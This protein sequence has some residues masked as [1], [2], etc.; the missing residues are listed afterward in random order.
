MKKILF[1]FA[2]L[3]SFSK[4]FGQINNNCVDAIPL[5]STPSFT[6]NAGSG[7]GSV[8]DFSTPA[9]YSVSNPG[10]NPG[11]ANSGCLHSGELNPQ[12]LLITIGNAGLL[13]FVF[14]AGNSAN[15]QVG[16]YD[17]A[18]WPY[19]PTTCADIFNN[20]L[21]PIRC[22]WNGTCSGG[23]GIA[24]A[25]NM[26]TFNGNAADFE[27]PLQVNACQQFIICI[28][29]YSGV[30]TLVS[31]LSMGTASLSCSPNCSPNYNVCY[32]SSATVTPV[33]YAALSS[34]TFAIP[35]LNLSN[36]TG[37]FVITPS[38]TTT[39]T[40]L[41]TGINS[42]NSVQTLTATS[43]ITVNPVPLVAPTVTNTS[44]TST[45]N[46]VDLHLTFFPTTNPAPS[47]TI[48]WST[49]PNGVTTSS[50]TTFTGGI[51]PGVYTATITTAA[52]CA[53]IT[54]FTINPQ[55]TSVN[56]IVNPLGSTH[57]IT[58][59]SNV[60]L[61]AMNPAYN[62]TW[63]STVAVFNGSVAVFTPTMVAT[64]TLTGLDPVSGCVGT[65]T[66][67]IG[68]NT[69]TPISSIAPAFQNITCNLSSITT[70]TA[71]A[72][73]SVNVTQIIS[74]PLG[75][76]FA[77]QSYSTIYTPGGVGV[78]TVCAVNDANG[79]TSC[80]T[81]TVA[82]N[83]GFPTYNIS[84]PDNFTLGCNSKSVAVVNIINGNT[85]PQGGP[86]SY[87]ILPPG[88][89]SV[90]PSGNLST[91]STY[92][93]TAPGT[94]TVIT[95]DNN[96]LC[97]TRT[98]ISIL[99]NI[100]G[101]DLIASVPRTVLDCDNPKVKLQAS[102]ASPNVSY[103][104]SFAGNPGTLQG[105]SITVNSVSTSATNS[106]V[107]NYTLTITD[108]SSTCKSD[109]VV[110]IRQNLYPPQV[111]ISG[112][113][114]SLTCKTGTFVL[115]NQS[116]TGIPPVTGFP[117]QNYV[118]GYIWQGPSPQ[119][120]LQLSTTYTA[121]TT[122][123]YTLTAKDLNN[124]CLGVATTSIGD[125]RT[126]PEVNKPVAPEPFTLDCGSN[127]RSIYA[128]VT[129]STS[130]YSYFWNAPP[131]AP[132]PS[133]ANSATITISKI[134]IYRVIVTNTV[135]GCGSVGEV[136]VINGTLNADFEMQPAK[137]PAPLSVTFFNN[138]TSSLGA[139]NISSY[140]SFGNGTSTVTN[141]NTLSTSN[142]FNLPGTYKVTMF[143]TKGTCLDT[144]V[145]YVEVDIPAT[146]EI[147]NV[148]TPNGDGANDLFFLKAANLEEISMVVFDR[149]GHVVYDI[150]SRT[151]NVAWDGKNKSGK[152]SAEGTYFYTL[153]A[154]GK[155]GQT[156][157]KKGTISLYR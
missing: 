19:S 94:Y 45:L 90:T 55:P 8:V 156:F 107:G 106:M 139:S 152:D 65:R 25:S 93:I 76:T 62:Y 61:T 67:V 105:D 2:L 141:A 57:T 142:V 85:S 150:I 100:L 18:M 114:V 149:W 36:T 71:T 126:Y 143:A 41:I 130:Q 21:A 4:T 49:I 14:G 59:I 17:W 74:S 31:F 99:N 64:Y 42:V 72:S 133:Q 86:V 80:K 101:P 140:W 96:S 63:S 77:A 10:T 53:T 92:S 7:P 131:G 46:A 117:Y 5:C 37:S 73:P 43:T 154:K 135:N 60:T 58:C 22:N 89:S 34:P 39:Y 13:E 129:G 82:S 145:K 123:L 132:L 81:F 153:K 113:S 127:I 79:C 116:K 44:C 69:I 12:W 122:G 50:Q 112:G 87:T 102:S 88:A 6:F 104:W 27:P 124:G 128:A 24:S 40:T 28:S 33:N 38:V 98:P 23:T 70:I 3:V 103:L 9:T 26:A 157:E 91:L 151:G 68:Q 118:I 119:Q 136:S 29:N 110:Q 20:T 48:N 137:G 78:F 155:D 11:S 83:Q 56:L 32:G 121:A 109:T 138:S 66:F 147:P 144:V 146:L 51:A 111:A 15:P 47:Y 120:P 125:N 75:G 95:K 16:C 97:E 52:G 35:A 134:G 30:N 84:S 148:F 115:T 108:N 54:S 1:F